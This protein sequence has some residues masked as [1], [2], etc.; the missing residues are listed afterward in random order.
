MKIIVHQ[1]HNKNDPTAGS[2]T[3][4]LLRLLP[5]SYQYNQTILLREKA[6]LFSYINTVP[7]SD[8]R[9]VQKTGT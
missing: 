6:P 3:V 8:G 4:T 1:N 5:S 7:G 2:P 9:C